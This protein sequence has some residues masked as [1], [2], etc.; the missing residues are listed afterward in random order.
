MS[1][2]VSKTEMNRKKVD[3]LRQEL[4]ALGLST[5]GLKPVLVERLMTACIS[6]PANAALIP[7]DIHDLVTKTMQSKMKADFGHVPFSE[8]QKSAMIFNKDAAV[9]GIVPTSV[10]IHYRNENSTMPSK[11]DLGSLTKTE[12]QTVFRSLLLKQINKEHTLIRVEMNRGHVRAYAELTSYGHVALH[13]YVDHPSKQGAMFAISLKTADKYKYE[14]KPNIVYDVYF[15]HDG[16]PYE[17]TLA[18]LPDLMLGIQWMKNFIFNKGIALTKGEPVWKIRHMW[19]NNFQAPPRNSLAYVR[20]YV[21]GQV[22]HSA[23]AVIASEEARLK[24]IILKKLK[25]ILNAKTK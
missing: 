3:E 20:T 21:T 4:S 15:Q 9:E 23:A 13:S 5:Q 6:A 14:G 2:S 24:P 7:K 8:Q 19:A 25:A 16:G 11:V 18:F 12:L 17:R 10:T 22:P 1:A